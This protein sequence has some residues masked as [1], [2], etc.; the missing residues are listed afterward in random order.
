MDQANYLDD[1][2]Q[3]ANQQFYYALHG[4]EQAPP[5][6][7]MCVEQVNSH[8][9]MAVG[10]MFVRKYFDEYSKNDVSMWYQIN[11][12]FVG[13]GYLLIFHIKLIYGLHA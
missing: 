8:L 4:T 5:R 7:Q 10:A 2:F 11:I 3:E 1:R 6:W 12:M 9:G 13:S